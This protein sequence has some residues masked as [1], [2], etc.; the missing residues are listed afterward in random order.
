MSSYDDRLRYPS[1]RCVGVVI[2]AIACL[3]ALSVG[4]VAL[5]P[6]ADTTVADSSTRP[7]H[8]TRSAGPASPAGADA[9]IRFSCAPRGRTWSASMS[10]ANRDAAPARFRVEV[11]VYESTTGTVVGTA[12]R[13]FSIAGLTRKDLHIARVATADRHGRACGV[14]AVRAG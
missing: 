6:R 13:E 5:W 9:L 4:V 2:A 11:S 1:R 10:V 3:T 7:T 8:P 12:R 14:S